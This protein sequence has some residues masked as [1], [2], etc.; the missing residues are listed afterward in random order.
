MASLFSQIISRKI[1]ADIIYEDEHCVAFRDIHPVAKIHILIV[2]RKEIPRL[3][4]ATQA[5]TSLLGHLLLVVN[6]IARQLG[7]FDSGYR[8]IINNGP[9]AGESIAHLHLHLLGGEPLGW[10][11]GG[12]GDDKI[13]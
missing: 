1:P 13:G 4:E 6:K 2:P 8:I 10:G 3:G 12:M 9:D 5:D 11:H 7:I